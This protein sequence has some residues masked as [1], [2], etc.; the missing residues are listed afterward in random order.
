MI[1]A[2]FKTSELFTGVVSP[3][4]TPGFGPTL[5]RAAFN[6][7][8]YA[9]ISAESPERRIASPSC[10]GSTAEVTSEP[11]PGRG[12]ALFVGGDASRAR[13]E[14]ELVG[15]GADPIAV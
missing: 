6:A 10:P 12:A 14:L 4:S 11:A 8:V 13:H 2:K 15:I 1:D 7:A 3:R 5:A 9:L